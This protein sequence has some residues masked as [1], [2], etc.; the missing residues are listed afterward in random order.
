MDL[1]IRLIFLS[2]LISTV[3][4]SGCTEKQEE[5][6]KTLKV[7]SAFNNGGWIPEKYTCSGENISPPLNLS[8]LSSDA[9]SIVI[10]ADDPDAPGGTFVHWI[11]WNIQPQ[12]TIPEGVPH[13]KEISEPFHAYQGK[14]DFGKYGYDGPCPPPGKPHTYR[15]KVYVLDTMLELKGGADISNLMKSMKGHVIQYGELTG[16]YG[17]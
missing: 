11:I 6:E 7:S 9:V 8:G 10:I 13:G 4:I 2:L 17:R 1:M 15:F 16:K 12:S 3:I 5:L 14:N